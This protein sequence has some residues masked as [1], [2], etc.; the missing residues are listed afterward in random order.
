MMTHFAAF[1]YLTV[2]VGG[3]TSSTICG[4]KLCCPTECR[5][6]PTVKH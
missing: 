1:A 2:T 4:M 6:V 3:A 5:I